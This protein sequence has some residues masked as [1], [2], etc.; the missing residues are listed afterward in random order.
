MVDSCSSIKCEFI[1]TLLSQEAIGH[2]CTFDRPY[3]FATL[4]VDPGIIFLGSK[5][6]LNFVTF[7]ILAFLRYYFEFVWN[8]IHS[9]SSKLVIYQVDQLLYVVYWAQNCKVYALVYFTK[10]FYQKNQF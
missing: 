7:G 3:L 5:S 2:A 6:S 9:L 10:D 4:K 8:S 1:V